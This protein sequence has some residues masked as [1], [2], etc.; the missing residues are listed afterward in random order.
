M[1]KDMYKVIV[2]R[3]RRGGRY[4]SERRPSSDPEDQPQ[5]E[6]L[7]FRHHSRKW[8]NEN[9]N[10]LRRYLGRQV[11]RRWDEV[12]SELCANID[13]RN[14]V[15]QHIHQHLEDFVA[16]KVQA[17]DGV[18]HYQLGYGGL[19][20][21]ADRW[22]PKLYVDPASGLLLVNHEGVQAR[23]EARREYARARQLRVPVDV[24]PVDELHQL[25]RID[26]IWYEIELA[27]LPTVAA[28]PAGVK[29]PAAKP[30]APYD[31]IARRPARWTGKC[32]GRHGCDACAPYGRPGLYARS[33]RQL[34]RHELQ[35]YGL[36]NHEAERLH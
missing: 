14:T 2:E 27:P 28:A 4:S 33:K 32:C 8:L 20:R 1:R 22:T 15:Q 13:R 3:P 23:R 19:R 25:R 36:S 26:G 11:G 24:R 17:I 30:I 16:L 7:K 35:R 10:P 21:L 5:H 12:Y 29:R 6:S 31:V 18:P 9:L 34:N